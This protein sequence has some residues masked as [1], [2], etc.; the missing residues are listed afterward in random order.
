MRRGSTAILVEE[1][2]HRCGRVVRP[3]GVALR[4]QRAMRNEFGAGRLDQPGQAL[5]YRVARTH[6]RAFNLRRETNLF[7]RR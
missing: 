4:E 2:P 7:G 5:T 6:G 3:R 1:D